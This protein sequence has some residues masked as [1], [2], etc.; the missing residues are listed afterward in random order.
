M[1][2]LSRELLWP[3]QVMQGGGSTFLPVTQI[4]AEVTNKKA[5][6]DR[7]KGLGLLGY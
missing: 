4:S 6:T 1:K 3:G 2:V 5:V 7:K